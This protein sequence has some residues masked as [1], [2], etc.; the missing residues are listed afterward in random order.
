MHNFKFSEV[1]KDINGCLLKRNTTLVVVALPQIEENETEPEESVKSLDQ[2]SKSCKAQKEPSC[3]AFTYQENQEGGSKCS[4]FSGKETIVEQ[5]GN[6]TVGYCLSSKFYQKKQINLI[7][8]LLKNNTLI[9]T[10]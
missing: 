2:C 1:D 9:C 6:G 5:P 10:F 3:E 4:L 8:I 7:E